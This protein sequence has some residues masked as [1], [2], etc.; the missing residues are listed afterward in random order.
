M[1]EKLI[2]LGTCKKPHGIKGGLSFTLYNVEESVLKKGIEVILFPIDQAS[3]VDAK[4]QKIA[5]KSISFGN[6]ITAYLEG[7]ADRNLVEE[8]IPFSIWV[9]RKALPLL[10]EG[11][12]YVEDLVGLEVFDH[13][14]G[15]KIGTVDSYYDNGMQIIIVVNGNKKIELPLVDNFFPVID[16]DNKRIEINLPQEI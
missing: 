14:S 1:S 13:A 11:E 12:F 10:L 9:A 7:V 8:M 5:I 2:E 6:K 3:S 16:T 15:K 4:G